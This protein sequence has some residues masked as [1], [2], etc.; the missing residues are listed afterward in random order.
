VALA[1][2]SRREAARPSWS[3]S[4]QNASDRPSAG[5][6]IV[7]LAQ[8]REKARTIL[9]ERQLGIVPKPSPTFGI[10]R[11]AYLA[12]RDERVR[13]RTRQADR[14]LLKPF[15]SLS[16][17]RIADIEALDI[18]R[19]LDAMAAPS[20]RRHAFIRIPPFRI[21]ASKP[22]MKRFMAATVT[23][24]FAQSGSPANPN[25]STPA[26]AS[27]SSTNPGAPATGANSFTEGQAKSRIE[28]AGF[29]DVSGLM[30][31][32][33]GIWRGKP[34]FTR[35]VFAEAAPSWPRGSRATTS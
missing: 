25:A 35:K 2:E 22:C 6:P 21:A 12:Q 4:A 13:A 9:A 17:K 24:T 33:D 29:S 31:D 11:E 30:K 18:E 16:Q 1:S 10:V 8:A 23:A 19:I 20:T 7:T 15:A 14:Y 34:I 3:S 27:P 32:K 5:Y 26:V 28:A